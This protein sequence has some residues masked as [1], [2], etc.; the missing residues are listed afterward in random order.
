VWAGT[1]AAL[2]VAYGMLTGQEIVTVLRVLFLIGMIGG[3]IGLKLATSRPR[4]SP[5][6]RVGTPS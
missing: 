5:Q 6:D 1:G 4:V 2:A 3:A